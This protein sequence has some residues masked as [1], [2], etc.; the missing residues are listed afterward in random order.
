M[1]HIYSLLCCIVGDFQFHIYTSI[2]AYDKVFE[3]LEL[4]RLQPVRRWALHVPVEAACVGQMLSSVFSLQA[5]HIRS[6][7]ASVLSAKQQ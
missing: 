5:P 7:A 1:S 6:N 2:F 3:S 4:Y